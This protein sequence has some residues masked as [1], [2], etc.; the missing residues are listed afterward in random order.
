[1]LFPGLTKL[2]PQYAGEHGQQ[3]A[4]P[5]NLCCNII[6]CL[7]RPLLYPPKFSGLTSESEYNNMWCPWM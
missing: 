5:C 7:F 4:V 6:L 2:V 3:R 1:M